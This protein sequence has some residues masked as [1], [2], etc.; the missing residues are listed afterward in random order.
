VPGLPMTIYHFS[1]IN[2]FSC[3]LQT[4]IYWP[5]QAN[6]L[7]ILITKMMTP[8]IR[9]DMRLFPAGGG[10][11]IVKVTKNGKDGRMRAQSTSVIYDQH[12]LSK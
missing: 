5:F 12:I 4:P 3:E 1:I 7:A 10:K 2:Q 9:Q 11:K 6:V 8:I